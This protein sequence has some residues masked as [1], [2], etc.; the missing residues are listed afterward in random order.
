MKVAL[1]TDTYLPQ[2][3]GVTNTLNHMTSYFDANNIEYLLFAP[4]YQDNDCNNPCTERFFS[5]RFFLYPECRLALPNAWKIQERLDAFEPDLIHNI[6]EFNMGLMG[7]HMAKKRNIPA[8]SNY[9]TNFAMYADYFKF[10]L[11]K[12]IIW[13]YMRWYHNQH[14]KTLTPSAEALQLLQKNGIHHTGIF[15]RGID[16]HRY[17]P[18][19]R[20]KALRK[21]LGLEHKTVFLYVGR[22]SVEKDLDVLKDAYTRL[23]NER[24]NEI[25]LVVVGEGPYLENCKHTFPSDTV[26][27]GFKTGQEL[28]DLY[29]S[30]DIFAFPSSTETFGNVVLEAMASGMAVIGADEGGVKNIIRDGKNGFLFQARNSQDLYEKMVTLLNE[31]GLRFQLGAKGVTHAKRQSWDSICEGLSHHYFETL[32]PEAY[33]VVS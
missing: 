25:A 11:A 2:I 29:A 18:N 22:V 4:D 8:I 15:T 7:L 16:T 12:N 9:T 21:E 17:S 10:P 31:K 28:A 1:F 30:C 32:L 19:H 13:E 20:S 14:A 26:F 33:E 27:T 6:T 24:G 23:K 3:N 5:L